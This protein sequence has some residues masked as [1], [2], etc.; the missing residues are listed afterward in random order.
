[1]LTLQPVTLREAAAFIERHHRHHKP[2]QGAKFAIG[3]SEGERVVGVVVVGRPVSRHLD[4][5]WT[6]EV[7]RCCTD[8]TKHAA[9][10]LYAA[11][12]RA[13]RAMGYKKLITYTLASENGISINA[14]GWRVIGEAGG[15][16]WNRTD[17][18]RVDTHPIGQKTLWEIGGEG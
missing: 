3:V 5:G 18:P 17:R 13:A 6:A 11:A 7:T 12:W 9:S 8:G 4:N 15:G 1:M 16:S 2:P 14:A 10:K